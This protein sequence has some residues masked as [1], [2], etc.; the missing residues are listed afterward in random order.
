MLNRVAMLLILQPP[1][2][3]PALIEDDGEVFAA[4]GESVGDGSAAGIH[5]DELDENVGFLFDGGQSQK[6]FIR[7]V[8]E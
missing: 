5:G 8:L 4:D 1:L 6:P 3:T 2:E 7:L